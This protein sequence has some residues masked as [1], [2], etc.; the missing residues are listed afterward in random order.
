[1]EREPVVFNLQDLPYSLKKE[2]ASSSD[3]LKTIY[4]RTRCHK[5]EDDNLN[6]QRCRNLK[7]HKMQ[8]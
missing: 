3:T 4:Q 5:T 7:F 1:V 8:G 6:L 2:T